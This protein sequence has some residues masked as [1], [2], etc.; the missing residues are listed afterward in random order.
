MIRSSPYFS[1]SRWSPALTARTPSR[2]SDMPQPIVL[3]AFLVSALLLPG[4]A[5]ADLRVVATTADLASVAKAVGGAHVDVSALALPTQ[6]P[7]F[8]DARPHLALDLARAD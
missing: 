3:A 7:H 6:D 2:R 1:A 8:V 5:R 4:A